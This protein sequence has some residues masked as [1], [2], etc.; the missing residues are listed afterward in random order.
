MT[1]KVA[2][3]PVCVD[4]EQIVRSGAERGKTKI[5]A[6]HGP[7][8]AERATSLVELCSEFK[9]DLSQ[10]LPFGC[11][12]AERQQESRSGRRGSIG[13]FAPLETDANQERRD[14]GHGMPRSDIARLAHAMEPHTGFSLRNLQ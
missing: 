13:E 5:Y 7:E 11:V 4:V 2:G 6:T 10:Q 14:A 8:Q 1:S 9:P 3:F 12:P